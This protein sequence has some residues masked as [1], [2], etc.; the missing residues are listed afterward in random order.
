MEIKFEDGTFY[1]PKKGESVEKFKARIEKIAAD[2]YLD[3]EFDLI[4]ID[5]DTVATNDDAALLEAV[6]TATGLQK[7][8]ITEVLAER[9][10]IKIKVA[11]PKVEKMSMEEMKASEDYKT[12]EAQIGKYC[13]F[14]PH[15]KTEVY[16]GKIA[17]I[18]LNKTNTR[19]YYTVVEESGKRRCCAVLNESVEFI[20]EPVK[21][22]AKAEP[23]TTSKNVVKST[24][25]KDVEASNDD[26]GDDLV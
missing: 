24:T 5:A 3:D 23:K 4:T 11:K 9:G 1:V 8:L 12:A 18:A 6:K 22:A 2:E 26:A 20:D 7:N 10:L 15:K 25:K 19:I 13:K 17:G 14:S 16:E 21:E